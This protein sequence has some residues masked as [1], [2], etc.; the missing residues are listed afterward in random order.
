MFLLF[1]TLFVALAGI[2]LLAITS[3]W[4]CRRY[5][6]KYFLAFCLSSALLIGV[7]MGTDLGSTYP[8]W[9]KVRLGLDTGVWG[10]VT[11]FLPILLTSRSTSR[12]VRALGIALGFVLATIVITF[13]SYV[14]S[15]RG[16]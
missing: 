15:F 7:V 16:V 3:S 12:I 6:I 10:S 2:L 5:G 4:I 8:R 9:M 14:G 11:L 13:F 1:L